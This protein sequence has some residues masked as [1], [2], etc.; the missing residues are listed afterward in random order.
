MQGSC[1]P[2]FWRCPS[3]S[4]WGVVYPAETASAATIKLSK[5][6]VKLMVKGSVTI[7][8]KGA[9]A[10]KVK[11]TSKNKK[12][13]TVS[14]GKIKG[15]KKGSTKVVATY[16]KK[17][18]T[19]TVTVSA[20]PFFEAK[21]AELLATTT[22]TVTLTGAKASQI[23]WSS[24]NKKI[25][26]VT[27]GKIKGIKKGSTTITAR[28]KNKNYTL[29]AKVLALPKLSAAKLSLTAGKTSTLKLSGAAA[30][31]TSWKSSN[32][33]A[34]T[35]SASKPTYA[36][37]DYTIQDWN[38]TTTAEPDVKP[39]M[40]E[41]N[42][43]AVDSY[44]EGNISLDGSISES[45]NTRDTNTMFVALGNSSVDE[46]KTLDS[47]EETTLGDVAKFGVEASIPEG[48]SITNGGK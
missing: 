48:V 23:K 22:K 19:A 32:T 21:S 46:T 6:S 20:V 17:N 39:G 27:K 16:N 34:A 10:K 3:F 47:E 29:T 8:L 37:P 18:Y 44:Q 14:G 13:A 5:T 4:E 24:K 40:M 31:K 9:T 35:A 28:Y 2:F 15:I 7:K 12:I 41:D 36:K 1:S 30:S 38:K 25:A 43:D 42:Y 11:W 45:A 26:T 33:K